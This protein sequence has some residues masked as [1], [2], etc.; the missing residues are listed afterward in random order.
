MA[1]V[2]KDHTHIPMTNSQ[3]PFALLT[4][5]QIKDCVKYDIKIAVVRNWSARNGKKF[6]MYEKEYEERTNKD[7]TRP[8]YFCNRQKYE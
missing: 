8:S 1:T 4:L 3:Q 7:K 2:P 5:G 6:E